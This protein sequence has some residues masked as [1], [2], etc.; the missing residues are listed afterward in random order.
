MPWSCFTYP[1][2]APPGTKNPG[3]VQPGLR[4]MPNTICF[5]YSADVPLGDGVRPDL[6][7][8]RTMPSMCFRY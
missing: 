3:G 5:S 4:G 1:A 8:P 6:D 2:D 7:D